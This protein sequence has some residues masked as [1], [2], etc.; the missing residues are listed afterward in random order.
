MSQRSRQKVALGSSAVL[1]VLHP[2]VFVLKPQAAKPRSSRC[3]VSCIARTFNRL[4]TAIITGHTSYTGVFPFRMKEILRNFKFSSNKWLNLGIVEMRMEENLSLCI[5]AFFRVELQGT[6]QRIFPDWPL[7]SSQPCSISVQCI[8][9]PEPSRCPPTPT[10]FTHLHLPRWGPSLRVGEAG[11]W[12]VGRS[13]CSAQAPYR[14]RDE[15]PWAGWEEG[16]GQ[17]CSCR[18][19]HPCFFQRMFRV[20]SHLEFWLS[21]RCWR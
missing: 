12:A 4:I 21:M 1:W 17:S 11:R 18:T 7:F 8:L 3:P 2:A 10:T 15:S 5:S 14:T 19:L 16:P 13:P 20:F 6:K 9:H